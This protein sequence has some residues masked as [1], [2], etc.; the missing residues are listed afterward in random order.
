M[1]VILFIIIMI[2]TTKSAEV[3]KDL[4]DKYQVIFIPEEHTNKED[5][6]FQLEVIRY[7]TSKGYKIV[8]AMEMFQQPFQ[9]FL[10]QYINCQID[11]E[12]MLE[13][14]EYTKRWGFDPALYRDIWRFAKERGI[15]IVAINIPSELVQKIKSEGLERV[16]DGSLPYPIIDQR[17]EE[18]QKL[19]EVLASH[20]KVEEKRFF[21]LQNAWDNGMALA[22]ARFLEKYPDYKVVVLVGK[23]HAEEYDSGIPRRLKIL[24][25]GVS[26][27][28]L[29]RSQRDF[30]FSMD[31]SKDSSSAN[32]IKEPNCKP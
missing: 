4:L 6:V 1:F 12:E 19:K 14:T 15:R 10:D 16:R 13:K 18:K 25:P 27:K 28:I 3:S 29:K 2:S 5:H 20:P 9:V 30:L 7:L 17:E 8:I 11:E 26:I 22:I 32:S 23:G 31:F 21:D 24:K